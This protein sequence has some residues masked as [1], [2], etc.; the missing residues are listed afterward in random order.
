MSKDLILLNPHSN[1][2]RALKNFENALEKA[3][4]EI[5]SKVKQATMVHLKSFEDINTVENFSSYER[6]FICAGDGTVNRLTQ[7]IVE[8]RLEKKIQV[9]VLPGG[10]GNAVAYMN[11]VTNM[12]EGL[13]LFSETTPVLKTDLL[14]TN[15]SDC[16]YATFSVGVGF[17]GDIVRTRQKTKRWFNFFSYF[18]AGF[19]E[20][21]R[22]K[23]GRYSLRVDGGAKLNVKATGIMLANGPFYGLMMAAP[24]AQVNDGF[25]DVR[26]FQDK[27]TYLLNLQPRNLKLFP[28]DNL[29]YIDIR[30]SSIRL[31]GVH[32]VQIDGDPFVCRGTMEVHVLRE[33]IQYLIREGKRK[34]VSLQDLLSA[35]FPD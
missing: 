7:R 16:P 6:V 12:Q 4:D 2:G 5:Q 14:Q 18:L 1:N 9:G 34:A 8:E 28:V 31:K 33:K 11:G 24:K 23:P 10:L 17:E 29:S 35:K 3:S 20:V 19:I 22:H 30:A 25:M 32:N 15:L 27:I 26:I 21:L 13:E